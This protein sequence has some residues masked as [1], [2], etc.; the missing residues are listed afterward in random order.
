VAERGEGSGAL[1][2][3]EPAEAAA[4]DV[5]QEHPLDRVAGAELEDVVERGLAWAP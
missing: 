3:A 4:R 2:A 5:L 1:D